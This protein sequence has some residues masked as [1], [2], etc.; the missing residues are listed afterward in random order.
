METNGILEAYGKF[1]SGKSLIGFQLCVNVQLPISK[2]GLEGGVLFLDTEGTF[3]T[4]RIESM[5][6]AAGL[7]PK[8]ALENMFIVRC[9]NTEQQILTIERADKLIS[10]NNVTSS[11]R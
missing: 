10:E 1:A 6:K 9:A 4:K 8:K 2:G 7:D 5:A 11:H 3:R